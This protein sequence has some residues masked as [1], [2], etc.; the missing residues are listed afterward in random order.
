MN[1][2]D[3]QLAVANSVAPGNEYRKMT[4]E[5]FTD[6]LVAEML[7]G[8]SYPDPS[9]KGPSEK[10]HRASLALVHTAK[11]YGYVSEQ[12]GYKAKETAKGKTP[13][14]KRAYQ[15]RCVVCYH[16]ERGEVKTSSYCDLC[17]VAICRES[18][19]HSSCWGAHIRICA[20]S[21]GIDMAP[22]HF[23]KGKGSG[24]KG[25][26]LSGGSIVSV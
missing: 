18:G 4:T 26:R 19:R 12:P 7:A 25:K 1:V 6:R 20:E 8:V 21:G 14:S 15:S 13:A 23:T 2:V 5:T 22:W 3:V 16:E 9:K 17:S 11:A 10:R 24:A